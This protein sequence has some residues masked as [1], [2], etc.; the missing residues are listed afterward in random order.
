PSE[1]PTCCQ[2]FFL[3]SAFLAGMTAL[4]SVLDRRVLKQKE[5]GHDLT[6]LLRYS[7]HL[8]PQ[9]QRNAVPDSLSE[10]EKSQCVLPTQQRE[11]GG[12]HGGA[13]DIH[14][15]ASRVKFPLCLGRRGTRTAWSS[16][17]AALLKECQAGTERTL[18]KESTVHTISSLE[19]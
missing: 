17:L 16:H 19:R 11:R 10:R 5:G 7:S 8:H 1:V 15:R 3:Y 12:S 2:D 4:R 9:M 14:L 6:L 13:T 18:W